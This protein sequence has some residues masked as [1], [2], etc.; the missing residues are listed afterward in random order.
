M[1]AGGSAGGGRRQRRHGRR[2]AIRKLRAIEDAGSLI[3]RNASRPLYDDVC[4]E[5]GFGPN[6]AIS[7][8]N[9]FSKPIEAS[10]R[11]GAQPAVHDGVL[12]EVSRL[13]PREPCAKLQS[14]PEGLSATEAAERLAKFGPNLVARERK[15]TI[16]DE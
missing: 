13:Q 10:A 12:A 9:V 1:R 7:P 16:A 14:A 2:A 11:T 15:A 6:L 4:C 5:R 3:C 8:M